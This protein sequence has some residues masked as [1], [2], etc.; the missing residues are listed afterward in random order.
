MFNNM[1]TCSNNIQIEL[2]FIRH[3]C[4][5]T[6]YKIY[7]I[8]RWHIARSL[9]SDFTFQIQIKAHWS[10]PCRQGQPRRLLWSVCTHHNTIPAAVASKGFAMVCVIQVVRK[11]CHVV[12][13]SCPC[14]ST[15]QKR[16]TQSEREKCMRVDVCVR[17][18]ERRER[19]ACVYIMC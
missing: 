12:C 6:L 9:D 19:C 10:T 1:N 14:A 4:T 16:H 11:W 17:E 7:V 3:I 8:L 18:R 2:N 5:V 15:K 13:R